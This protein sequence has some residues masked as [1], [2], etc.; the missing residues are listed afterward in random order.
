[1]ADFFS[2]PSIA[3]DYCQSGEGKPDDGGD[4]ECLVDGGKVENLKRATEYR[5]LQH[6][7]H[8]V[9]TEPGEHHGEFHVLLLRSLHVIVRHPEFPEDRP[10]PRKADGVG[11]KKC[12]DDAQHVRLHV[13]GDSNEV[14][15]RS[16]GEWLY[17]IPIRA[18]VK[19]CRS[20]L[21]NTVHTFPPAFRL[22]YRL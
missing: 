21:K 8:E 7:E 5:G 13:S 20:W 12:E 11:D 10:V 3:V 15:H 1:M 17:S 18:F 4:Q 19:E 2:F 14:N 6:H 22:Y 16:K 9:C